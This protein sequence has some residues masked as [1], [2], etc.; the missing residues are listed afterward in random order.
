MLA[1][2]H[3]LHVITQVKGD[4]NCHSHPLAWFHNVLACLGND[5][6]I[7]I[8][9][10]DGVAIASIFSIA[11]KQNVVCKYGFARRTFAQ[12]WRDAVCFPGT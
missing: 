12:S 2:L 10:K 4:S 9:R 11:H 8:A 7:R 5:A 1:E 3:K 6:Q